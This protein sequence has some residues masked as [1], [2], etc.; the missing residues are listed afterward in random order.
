[1]TN[2][3]GY[4]ALTAKS[5][6]QP[7]QFSRR[8]LGICD[9]KIE[10]HYSGICHSD[11]HQA[12]EEWGS[13][14]FPMVPGHEIAGI[15]SEIGNSVSKFKVGDRV[16][17]GVFVDSCRNCANCRSGDENYCEK[18][19]TATYNDRERDGLTPTYGG[20]SNNIVVDENYV[21]SIP[22]N[23]A[24]SGVAPLLCAGITLYSPM[25]FWKVRPGMKVAIIGLGGLGHMGLKIAKAMG[26][27]VTVLS[28]S[29]NKKDDAYQMGADD[30]YATI[31][32]EVFKGL[33]GKFDLILNTVSAEH[34]INLY[35]N[36]LSLNGT[37]V[38]LGLPGKPFS[39]NAGVLLG[40]RRSMAGSTIGGMRDLQE[41]INFCGENNILSEVE[42]I[43]PE[44]IN[45]AF[46]RTV[47]SDVRYRFV[48]DASKF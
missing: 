38:I 9:L 24:L 11:I 21:V 8:N 12:R 10:I 34:D 33:K 30:F 44:Y 5:P 4:A 35:L 18:N 47:A 2:A 17:V 15:V 45:Q 22:A 46:T 6:L 28:H 19:M 32:P 29:E 14:I 37:L 3:R 27:H 42:I 7:W 39:V 23:L 41:M 25:K 48:I 31:S 26:A 1:M 43:D 20:Y 36:T 13:A 16:G 40:A